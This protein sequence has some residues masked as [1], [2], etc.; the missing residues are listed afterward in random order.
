MPLLYT[1]SPVDLADEPISLEAVSRAMVA[2]KDGIRKSIFLYLLVGVTPWIVFHQDWTVGWF[3]GATLTYIVG[4]F[5]KDGGL[6]TPT[7][8]GYIKVAGGH[9]P[10]NHSQ[11][12]DYVAICAAHGFSEEA[13]EFIGKMTQMGRASPTRNEMTELLKHLRPVVSEAKDG[14]VDAAAV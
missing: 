13:S 1:I 4:F 5:V 14:S 8:P 9:M 3:I 12:M 10:I 2:Y 11:F 7:I 6:I